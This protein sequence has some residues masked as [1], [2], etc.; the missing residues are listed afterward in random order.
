MAY[1]LYY[2]VG[3]SASGATYDLSDDLSSLTVEQQEGQ[4][5]P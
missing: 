2:R 4:P 3:I 5:T 1:N